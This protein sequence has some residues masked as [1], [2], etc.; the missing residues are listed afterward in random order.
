MGQR[1]EDETRRA[2]RELV[3]E[4]AP[5]GPA[6][7]KPDPELVDDLGYHSLALLELAFLLEDEFS[8]PAIDRESAQRIQRVSDVENYVVAQ[9]RDRDGSNR[10]D[11]DPAEVT[12]PR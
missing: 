12:G 11:S 2:I 6:A 8:L 1:N 3:L 4:M 5:A 9:L 10:D 7:D